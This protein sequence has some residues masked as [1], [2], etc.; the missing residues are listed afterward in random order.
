MAYKAPSI[1]LPS[2]EHGLELPA[3]QQHEFQL[4]LLLGSKEP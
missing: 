2:G 3:T 4:L 1:T